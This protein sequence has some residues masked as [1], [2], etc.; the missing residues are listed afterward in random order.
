M[1]TPKHLKQNGNTGQ[2]VQIISYTNLDSFYPTFLS[3][4]VDKKKKIEFLCF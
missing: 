4:N 3:K 1:E 2:K